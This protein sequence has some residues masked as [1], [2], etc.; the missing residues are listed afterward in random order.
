MFRCSHFEISEGAAAKSSIS[1]SEPVST[2]AAQRTVRDYVS[3]IHYLRPWVR[4]LL[5]SE[6]I[7]LLCCVLKVHGVLKERR[8]SEMKD[9]PRKKLTSDLRW[10]RETEGVYA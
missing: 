4:P 10:M 2:R 5:E 3:H 6:I 7:V 1:L 8:S 9:F